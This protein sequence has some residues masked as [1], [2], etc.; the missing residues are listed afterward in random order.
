[1]T[2]VARRQFSVRLSVLLA[3]V[4]TVFLLIGGPAE[5]EGPPARTVEYVVGAG[6]TLWTI[7]SDY[8]SPGA[9]IRELI[10]DIRARSGLQTSLIHPGQ[11]L[12]IPTD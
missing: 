6:D 3:A 9:D 4:G 11:I 2:Q 12:N 10:S 1:M 5:A 8:V 7:A